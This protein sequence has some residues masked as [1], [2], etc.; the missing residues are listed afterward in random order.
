[1]IQVFFKYYICG[2]ATMNKSLHA[3]RHSLD[4]RERIPFDC[5]RIYMTECV[6]V[7]RRMFPGQKPK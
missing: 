4:K 2:V 6:N 3:I 7:L 5:S 1:M